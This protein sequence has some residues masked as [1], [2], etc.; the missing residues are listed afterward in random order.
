MQSKPTSSVCPV[1]LRLKQAR[2]R[3]G[4]SQRKL[5][6]AAGI[7]EA[8]SSARMNQYERGKHVPDFDTLVKLAKVLGVPVSYFYCIDDTDAEFQLNFHQ[9]H[10][11]QQTQVKQLLERINF[12]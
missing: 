8:S 11:D 6:I 12:A 3:C 1:A 2:V 9:L 10:V 5:G 7:D 4:L